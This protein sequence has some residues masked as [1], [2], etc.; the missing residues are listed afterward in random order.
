[1]SHLALIAVS[2]LC[3]PL[4]KCH[5]SYNLLE[6]DGTQSSSYIMSVMSHLCGTLSK[7]H[8]MTSMILQSMPV[9]EGL[10]RHHDNLHAFV[11]FFGPLSWL[12][13]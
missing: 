11:V 2:L 7:L 9:K 4:Q 5:V 13:K 3:Q 6:I 8:S 10:T 1:M 12:L